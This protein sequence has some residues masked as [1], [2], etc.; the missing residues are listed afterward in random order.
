MRRSIHQLALFLPLLSLAAGCGD[1]PGQGSADA[2]ENKRVEIV[3]VLAKPVAPEQA[4]VE[5]RNEGDSAISLRGWT[6]KVGTKETRLV[7]RTVEDSAEAKR[8]VD[9]FEVPGHGLALIVDRAMPAEEVARIACES[10]IAT[11]QAALGSAHGS[12]TDVLVTTLGMQAQRHCIPVLTLA[13]AS[14]ATALAKAKDMTLRNQ[15]TEMS[16][17]T[18]AFATSPKGVAWEREGASAKAFAPSPLGSTPGARNFFGGNAAEKDATPA[19]RAMSSSPWRV[20]DEVMQ[21]RREAAGK[22][23]A[24]AQALLDQAASLAKGEHLPLNPLVDPF[25]E[26]VGEADSK[27]VGAFYQIN[28]PDV[29]Q[30]LLK[31]RKSGVDI[32]LATDANFHDDPSYKDGLR[33]MEAAGIPIAYDFG[34]NGKNRAPLMHNKFL[35]V[36]G[37][38]LWS[39]SFNPIDDE[40]SRIHADNVVLMK[41]SALAKLHEEEFDI[42]SSGTWGTDKRGKGRGGMGTFVDGARVDIRFSPGMTMV[43][44]QKR[45]E[46][47]VRTGDPM[48]AC[49]AVAGAKK[50]PVIEE[51]YRNLDPCGGPYDLILGEAARAK[52]SIYFVSFS[53]ALDELADIMV[54]RLKGGV[55]VKGVVDPTVYTRGAPA[56]ILGAGADVRYTPN[57][58]PT[59]AAWV[60]PKTNCPS[61]PNK[62]WLH[63]KFVLVDY[64]TDH[65]VVITGSHNMS[66]S[67]EQ[68]NDETLVVIRDRAVAE[69]YY[70][71]F[72]EA[73]DH[74]QTMGEHRDTSNLPTLAITEAKASTDP[75]EPQWIELLNVGDAPV[76]LSGLGLWNRDQRVSLGSGSVAAGA[77]AVVVLGNGN[78]AVPGGVT[79]VKVAT[80]GNKPFLAPLTSLVLSAADGRWITTYDPYTSDLNLPSGSEAP[81]A[82]TPWQWVGFDRGALDALKVELLGVNVT[83]NDPVPT[84]QPRGFFSDWADEHDVTDS[85]LVLMKGVTM[86]WAPA[87]SAAGTPGAP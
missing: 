49:Q 66:D 74:P 8:G 13:E 17:A 15:G 34:K 25:E 87:T 4:F 20:G 80:Q 5:L 32:H 78:V 24:E 21:L 69:V 73:F 7:T 33:G 60:K 46:E 54:E 72:R 3:E 26:L 58:D 44:V 11:T 39:G 59:C 57:S 50:S 41:S 70:R 77:R 42:L 37:R 23:G 47:L 86:P 9:G 10:P 68:Q 30:S 79:V 1:E 45:G 19:I 85:S 31:A 38:W 51:R 48:K 18:A 6:L 29:I 71:I 64:G 82:G 63:H 35:T 36:D 22:G 62:V 52:S 83:P 56:K 75:A 16:R 27:A 53:L 65:P 28:E 40:P 67:A 2:T 43:Q 81:A 61:N 12:P 14:L 84:W 76:N 55:D